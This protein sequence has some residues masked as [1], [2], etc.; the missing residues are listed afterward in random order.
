MV[1]QVTTF[2]ASDGTK[3]DNE[4]D[5]AAH[6]T[7]LKNKGKYE[8]FIKAE[9][10]HPAQAGLMRRL[11]PRFDTFSSTWVAPAAVDTSEA[12]AA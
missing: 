7:Y 2:E 12:P 3:F 9:K 5:A 6:E 8:A 4:A 11:L 10:L 1:K